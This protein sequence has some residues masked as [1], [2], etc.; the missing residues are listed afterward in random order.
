MKEED[1]SSDSFF[2]IFFEVT[3][4]NSLL[5]DFYIG[6]GPGIAAGSSYQIAIRNNLSDG[7]IEASS[8][9]TVPE[10]SILTLLGL[11]LAGLGYQRR[12]RMNG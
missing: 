2:D 3:I 4:D 9:P 8:Y 11:G 10:P 12:K 6:D 1:F 7:D 5:V